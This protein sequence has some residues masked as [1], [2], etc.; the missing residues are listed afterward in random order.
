MVDAH[1][2]N[3]KPMIVSDNTMEAKRLCDSFK[4]LGTQ[5]LNASEKLKLK[6]LKNPGRALEIGAHVSTA[7]ASGN[8]KRLYQHYQVWESSVTLVMDF[9]SESL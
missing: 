3:D 6:V 1:F 7:F 9:I 5:G 8:L 4:S 2:V